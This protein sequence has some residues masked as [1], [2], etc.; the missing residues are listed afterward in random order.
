MAKNKKPVV[1][2]VTKEE[3]EK[4]K[5]LR[6]LTGLNYSELLGKI[7]NATHKRVA[8]FCEQAQK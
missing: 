4:L 8:D 5:A 7:L 1:I 6:K 2:Y 3:H